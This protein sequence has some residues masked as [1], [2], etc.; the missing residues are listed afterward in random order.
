[1]LSAELGWM[2]LGGPSPH[3]TMCCG[4]REGEWGEHEQ[5]WERNQSQSHR[6][7]FTPAIFPINLN[8]GQ[9]FEPRKGQLY[10]HLM[11]R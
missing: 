4:E 11:G 9:G 8:D 1:M 6:A 7:S 10:K 5:G 2:L 3:H